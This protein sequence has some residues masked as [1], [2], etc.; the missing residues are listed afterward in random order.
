MSGN[1]TFQPLYPTTLV[2]TTAIQAVPA[3]QASTGVYTFR[4]KN[5][6]AARQYI[7]WGPTAA[8]AIATAPTAAAPQANI[9]LEPGQA[10]YLC[11][12]YNVFFISGAAASIE[13]TPGIGGS[14]AS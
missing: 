7:G 4:V 3:G 13:V 5:I 8:G 11:L 10:A 6:N 1:V 9:G 2:G 12:P 14:G